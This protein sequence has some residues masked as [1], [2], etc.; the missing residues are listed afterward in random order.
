V[1]PTGKALAGKVVAA[2]LSGKVGAHGMREAEPFKAS[3]DFRI[4]D[5]SLTR[6][7]ALTRFCRSK[8]IIASRG[9]LNTS[10]LRPCYHRVAIA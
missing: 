9:S 1:H 2:N 7:H 4:S 6:D 5:V 10:S 8:A 3:L